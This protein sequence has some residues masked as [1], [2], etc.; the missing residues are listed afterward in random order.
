MFKN[1]S[2]VLQRLMTV[3]FNWKSL[4]C[5][6]VIFQTHFWWI[7]FS[8]CKKALNNQL[9]FLIQLHKLFPISNIHCFVT[10]SAI[11]KYRF[12]CNKFPWNMCP[13]KMFPNAS[14]PLPKTSTHIISQLSTLK[15]PTPNRKKRPRNPK[16]RT[17]HKPS[18]ALHHIRYHRVYRLG[19]QAG[20]SFLKSRRPPKKD[21]YKTVPCKH[22]PPPPLPSSNIHTLFT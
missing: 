5:K 17:K 7:F 12:R 10:L 22:F 18:A 16:S 6:V 8:L 13:P 1:N 4:K 21:A 14:E 11:Q 9:S 20:K 3:N 15:I 19:R 2:A